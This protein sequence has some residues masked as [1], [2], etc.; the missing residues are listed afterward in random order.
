MIQPINEPQS[1]IQPSNEPAEHDSAY[2]NAW[3]WR[4]WFSL[5][6]TLQSMVQPVNESQSTIQPNNEPAEHDS[7]YINDSIEIDSAY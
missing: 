1:M 5:L 6:I 7:A 4:D 3:L 2:I